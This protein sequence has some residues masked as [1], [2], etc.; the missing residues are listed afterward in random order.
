MKITRIV[1]G[2]IVLAAG[3]SLSSRV[4]SSNA[5]A[6]PQIVGTKCL[7]AG[8]SRTV[9]GVRFS[10]ARSGK[11]LKWVRI[12]TS[13]TAVTTTTVA[14]TSTTT[15]IA[16]T[17]TTTKAVTTTTVASKPCRTVAQITS[18][19]PNDLQK[20]EW[21]AVVAKLQPIVAAADS[22][23]RTTA[24][25]DTFDDTQTGI[26]N[27]GRYYAMSYP[28]A[29]EETQRGRCSYLGLVFGLMVSFT[30][31]DKSDDAAKAGIQ[32][33]TKALLQESLAK[34][35]KVDGY[36]VDV[37]LIEPVLDYCPGRAIMGLRTQC[38]WNDYGYLYFRT[39]ALTSGQVAA[40]ATTDIFSLSVSGA[41]FPPRPFNQIVGIGPSTQAVETGSVR[42][43]VPAA[44]KSHQAYTY[45]EFSTTQLELGQTIAVDSAL[46]V[47][48]ISVDTVGHVSIVDGRPASGVGAGVSATIQTRIYRYNG[49][50]DIPVA[51]RRSDFS[52][53]VDA[54]QAVLFPHYSSATLNLPSGTTLSPGKYLI[55]F[56]VSGWNPVGSYIRIASFAE[57]SSGQTDVYAPGKAYRACNLRER[58]GY[59]MTDNPQVASIG[60]ESVGTN[61]NL[62]YP[63]VSK[64]ENPA[65]GAQHTWVWS[66]I[67]MTL[68]AP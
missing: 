17:S 57:G 55:T 8:T 59:R 58:I 12:A 7:K 23:G 19:L 46:A 25:I 2:V 21:E 31:S 68:N 5:V 38:P 60:D 26:L 61:C 11:T 30:G 22:T 40:T 4:D 67:A 18:R 24:V 9:K 42:K 45:V 48:S 36:D 44:N 54:T 51:T 63:E 28:A 43:L 3:L 53:Q 35:T 29:I 6:N 41:T 47:N 32:A 34:Y 64:G 50:G 27:Y 65:R 13:T 20:R 16:T 62:F 33:A 39:A 15:S 14:T 10:C 66:D 49:S 52:L 56:T 37:I 1:I